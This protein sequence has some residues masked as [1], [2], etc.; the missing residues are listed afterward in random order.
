MTYR[1]AMN[2]TMYMKHV[3]ASRPLKTYF[4]PTQYDYPFFDNV[5]VSFDWT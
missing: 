2:L 4:K 5:F 1:D 3:K